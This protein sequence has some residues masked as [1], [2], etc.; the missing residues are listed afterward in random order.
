MSEYIG[1]KLQYTGKELP[2]D[3]Y[4][5]LIFVIEKLK[6]YNYNNE[7]KIENKINPY[8]DILFLNLSNSKIVQVPE[9]IQ[10]EGISIIPKEQKKYNSE[11]INNTKKNIDKMENFIDKDEKYNIIT[12]LLQ[13][14]FCIIFIIMSLYILT[15]F[16]I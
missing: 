9:E 3:R 7:H 14:I 16:K 15:L 11:Q 5:T 10:K 4:K 1:K 8:V 12:T 13:I 6:E 2:I